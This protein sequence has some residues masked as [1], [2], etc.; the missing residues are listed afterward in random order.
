M[1]SP[2]SAD[3]DCETKQRD[4]S[5][6]AAVSGAAPSACVSTYSRMFV[7][8]AI[9]NG[10]GGEPNGLPMFYSSAS[11]RGESKPRIERSRTIGS[12]PLPFE[13]AK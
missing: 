9:S 2:R 4:G 1:H 10:N 6:S 13:M 11:L 12:S 5:G 7:T 3:S 8:F